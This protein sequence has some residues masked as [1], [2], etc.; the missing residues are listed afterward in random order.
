MGLEQA[1]QNRLRDLVNR[2]ATRPVEVFSL[3]QSAFNPNM[4]RARKSRALATD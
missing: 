3:A 2:A 4:K 1:F